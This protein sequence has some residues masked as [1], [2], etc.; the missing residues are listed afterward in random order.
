MKKLLLALVALVSMHG[1]AQKEGFSYTFYGQVRADYYYNSR[2]SVETVDGLYYYTPK[3]ES[4]DEL[5]QDLN[6][7]AESNT[8]LSYS[9]LGLN[10]KGMDIG[11]FHTGAK[12]ELDFRGSGSTLNVIRLRHAY[13]TLS[14]KNAEILIGQTWHP[15]ANNIQPKMLNLNTGA[16][17]HPFNRS[18]MVRYTF[19]KHSFLLTAAAVWQ[20]QYCSVGPFGT[21]NSYLKNSNIPEIVLGVDY[22]D[23]AWK[24]GTM[25]NLLSIM[26]ATE[27]TVAGKIYKL[28]N[29]L[30]TMSV[31]GHFRY[32]K[33]KWFVQG[34]TLYAQNMAHTSMLGGYGVSTIKE[35]TGEMSYSADRYQSSW[36][37]L[38]YGK[39]WK[40]GLF[41]G[42]MKNLD[43]RHEI[44][45]DSWGKA[46][47]ISDLC[48]ASAQFT[49]NQP[50]IRT[51]LE[52]NF[53]RAWYD[54]AVN[55]H[56]LVAV[57]CYMF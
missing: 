49:Y 42:Y 12:V 10:M 39:I 33:E 7:K 4:F 9:R 14:Y 29:R 46:R 36:I 41:V 28:S 22:E 30:T 6:D 26:P 16:P 21:G 50:H 3:E 55:N 25:A 23:K 19:K 43:P 48:T 45:G 2:K 57:V 15:M 34:E 31:G 18:P 8:Y 27:S 20:Q 13:V 47:G 53:T 44:I 40:P 17:F 32:A 5:G 56:R 54:K 11:I 35:Q 1:Y 52:Y 38:L 51:G 37:N 24:V